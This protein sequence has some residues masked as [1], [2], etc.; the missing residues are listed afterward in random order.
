MGSGVLEKSMYS[1]T[2]GRGASWEPSDMGEAG[3]QQRAGVG[4]EGA[5]EAYT[6]SLLEASK[7]WGEV[8][9]VLVLDTVHSTAPVPV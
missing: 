2:S 6:F 7:T 1:K 3:G 4:V 5:K 9:L 8:T